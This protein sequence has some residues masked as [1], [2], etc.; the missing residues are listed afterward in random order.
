MKIGSIICI[1]LK[2][3][4]DRKKFMN[5]QSKKAKFNFSFFK[6]TKHVNPVRGC[7][8]SHLSIIKQN[9]IKEN[10]LILEDDAKFNYPLKNLPEPPKDWDMLY[11]GA[12]TKQIKSYNKNWNKA[13]ECW[14]THAYIIRKSIYEKVITDL[15]NYSQEIDK[16]YVENIQPNYNCYILT[17]P[18]TQQNTS[19]S[20]IEGK[21][22]NYDTLSTVNNIPYSMVK[23]EII[24][25]DF[26]LKLDDCEL[27]NISIITI[28][29]NRRKFLPLLVYNYQ[30]I[31]Y[32]QDKIEWIIIDDGDEEI[33]DLLPKKNNVKYVHLDVDKPLTVGYKR[34]YALSYAQ[35]EYIVHMDDDD[36]YFKH[37]VLSRVKALISNK[38][39][40]IGI[41]IVPC[42]D[43]IN[44]LGFT[45]G[46]N[47]SILAEASMCYTRKFWE[48]RQYNENVKT[49][50]A[51]LFL[52]DRSQDIIQIPYIFVMIA[53]THS[54]NLTCNLR[55]ITNNLETQNA[56]KLLM[57]MNDN[58]IQNFINQF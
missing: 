12:T 26:I 57:N 18:M 41:T 50:E 54:T 30:N 15:E 25:N 3:R 16:Y 58:Y 38:K 44:K 35:G 17:K 42:M 56:F 22:V 2:T 9:K 53:L 23:H 5:R 52:K 43:I 6:T 11:L 34:N 28:T 36:V 45:I 7:L 1:N 29:R 4:K 48:E 8:E 19:Y 47:H 37:S 14:S 49:G 32:P 55:T 46:S 24:N 51:L 40:C 31:D 10:I 33:K 13:I 39:Q 21:N 20:D 27:P